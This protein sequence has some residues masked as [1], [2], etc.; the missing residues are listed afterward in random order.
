VFPSE[1]VPPAILPTAAAPEMAVRKAGA[2][3]T[4]PLTA[5]TQV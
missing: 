2:V 1:A 5:T 3:K 4:I